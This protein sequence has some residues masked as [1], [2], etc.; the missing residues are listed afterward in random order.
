MASSAHPLAGA[1]WLLTPALTIVAM[2]H[3]VMGGTEVFLGP[4]LR[5]I[6]YG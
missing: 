2:Y 3:H 1:W 6:K 5:Y 4:P